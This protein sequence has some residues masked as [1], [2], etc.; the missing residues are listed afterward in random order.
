MKWSKIGF[1][2]GCHWCTEGIFSTIKGVEKVEQGWIASQSPHEDYSEA[3]IVYYNAEIIGLEE[4]IAIHLY[5]HSATSRHKLRKKYR[6]A[7]YYFEQKDKVTGQK[8]IGK[9]QTEFKKEI[10]TEVLLFNH[11]IENDEKYLN[12]FYCNPK[13]QFCFRYIHPKISLLNYRFQKIID[14]EKLSEIKLHAE[15]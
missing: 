5:T 11:F 4:L 1:G 10:I 13:N 12:Y 2:G 7:I 6:S 9:L 3:V 8:T 15:S 14:T